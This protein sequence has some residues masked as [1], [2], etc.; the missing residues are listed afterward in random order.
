MHHFDLVPMRRRDPAAQL[1]AAKRG[2]GHDKGRTFHF[3]AQRQRQWRI[4]LFWAMHSEA[5]ARTAKAARQQGDGGRI[6][7]EMGMQ[8][9][10]A[11]ITAPPGDIGGLN[12]V[13]QVAQAPPGANRPARTP[14]TTTQGKDQCPNALGRM[15]DPPH[16]RRAKQPP[17]PH[18]QHMFGAKIL[19]N[20]A[21]IDQRISVRAHGKAVNGHCN[22]FQRLNLAPDKGVRGTRIGVDQ[23]GKLHLAPKVLRTN[24]AEL[25]AR[26]WPFC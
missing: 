9:R 25:A 15:G 20:V 2:N 19:G 11:Q 5:V 6:G 18:F 13:D 26:L 1:A 24:Y 12:Q 10:D 16:K 8:V 17:H 3:V 22:T 4:K 7:A 23:I 21:R 14:R